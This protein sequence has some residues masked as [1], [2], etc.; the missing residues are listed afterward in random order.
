MSEGRSVTG[1]PVGHV[2]NVPRV[3]LLARTRMSTRVVSTAAAEAGTTRARIDGAIGELG[4]EMARCAIY[5]REAGGF[6]STEGAA[7]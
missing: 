5:L 6:D 7:G 1:L 4:C 2:G 3:T